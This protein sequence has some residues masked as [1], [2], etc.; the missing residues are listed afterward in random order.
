M[1]SHRHR[2]T[3]HLER[4][5]RYR[6]NA[7]LG[8]LF[9]VAGI[10]TGVSL[11]LFRNGIFLDHA[12]EAVLGILVFLCG[13]SATLVGCGYWLKAK[14]WNEAIVFIGLMPVGVLVIPFVRLIVLAAPGMLPVGM[15]MMPIVLIVVV[16][17]LPDKSGVSN[18]RPVWEREGDDW[19]RLGNARRP[20]DTRSTGSALSISAPAAPSG[21]PGPPSVS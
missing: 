15:V 12:N 18:K 9:G 21:N 2:H 16:L 1:K 7:L 13:Y 3:T 19:P 11:V 4:I 20:P 17:V 6:K 8:I 10:A 5:I 14:A